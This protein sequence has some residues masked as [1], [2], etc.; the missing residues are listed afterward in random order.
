VSAEELP[1]ADR[2]EGMNEM[3]DRRLTSVRGPRDG[4]DIKS[5]RTLQQAVALEIGQRG[6]RYTT[7]LPAVDRFGWMSVPLGSARLDLDK[8]N[9]PP[10]DGDEIQFPKQV[11][12]AAG[13]DPEA[14]ASQVS[15][16]GVFAEFAE[17]SRFASGQP[18]E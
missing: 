18:G 15:R 8:Y 1:E 4:H 9:D 6:P 16:G 2:F 5:H 3:F 13:D 11:A 14:F 12:R 7:L 17:G 10:I